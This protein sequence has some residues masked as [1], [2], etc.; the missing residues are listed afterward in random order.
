MYKL[1]YEPSTL[2]KQ[3]KIAGGGLSSAAKMCGSALS[4]FFALLLLGERAAH[5]QVPRIASSSRTPCEYK[6][7]STYLL[8]CLHLSPSTSSPSLRNPG[9]TPNGYW[10]NNPSPSSL[11]S[12]ASG[13]PRAQSQCPYVPLQLR[14][15]P[16]DLHF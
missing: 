11:E 1:V 13:I 16:Y 14:S 10:I 9:Q 8:I 5:L 6:K 4:H 12:R 15:R 2:M 7:S 3:W